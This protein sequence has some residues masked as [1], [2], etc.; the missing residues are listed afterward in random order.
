M[1]RS[2]TSRDINRAAVTCVR[3]NAFMVALT[4]VAHGWQS[5][6]WLQISGLAVAWPS[7]W[8]GYE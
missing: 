5:T 2:V 3:A 1:T 4:I 8:D 7:G 6:T